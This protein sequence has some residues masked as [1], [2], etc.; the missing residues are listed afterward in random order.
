MWIQQIICGVIH[1]FVLLHQLKVTVGAMQDDVMSAP[2]KVVPLAFAVSD[3]L[4][5]F[6]WVYTFW[7]KPFL[8]QSL[9]EEI[10]TTQCVTE[11]RPWILKL[12]SVIFTSLPFG[13]FIFTYLHHGSSDAPVNSAIFIDY[14]NQTQSTQAFSYQNNSTGINEWE[15]YYK[16][17]TR[18][19]SIPCLF[20]Y[21]CVDTLVLILAISSYEITKIYAKTA[22]NIRE[23][24]KMRRGSADRAD[25]FQKYGLIAKKLKAY[26]GSLNDFGSGF[27]FA[28]FCMIVP[29]LSFRPLET[30][31]L[32]DFPYTF[33]YNWT[34]T[35]I[36]I[37]ILGCC[38][39]ATRQS[40]LFKETVQESAYELNYV[41]EVET[42]STLKYVKYAVSQC[43]VKGGRFFKFSYGLL[44]NIVCGVIHT[45]VLFHQLERTVG[46]MQD[47]VMSAPLKVVPL[48]FTVSDAL[49]VFV[50][51]YTFWRKPLLLQSL[52]VEISTTQCL[53][54]MRPWVLK[55][56]SL[57]FASLPFAS[58]TFTYLHH[59]SPDALNSVIIN[60]AIFSDYFNQTQSTQAFSY[61]SNSTGNISAWEIY[62]KMASRITG[63][64]GIPGLFIFQC[65]ETLVLILAISSYEITKSY[66]KSAA[67]IREEV[68]SRRGLDRADLFQK[69]GLIAK[70][71]KAYFGGLNDFGSGFYFAWFC[72]I[73]PWLSFRPLETLRHDAFPY[74]FMFNWTFILIYIIILGC[75]AEARRQCELL[76]EFTQESAYELN[77][78]AGEE[79]WTTLKYV[80]YAVSQC[81]VK[82]GRFFQ[83]SYG[84]LGN[85]I[86][87][88][89]A[90]SLLFIQFHSVDK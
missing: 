12:K 33:A 19:T 84:F 8:L 63:V 20:I 59:G 43:G 23:E 53:T 7:R 71:L 27:Y 10:S 39:E 48:A 6:F 26:F 79:I 17:A 47:D 35:L 73:V 40:E 11:M 81:G 14:Y 9:I 90:Y 16:L 55:L 25:L 34:F 38:A 74:T 28:W 83:F 41:A 44:G 58:F 85:T 18:I 36:Y 77:S 46:A 65:V 60:S 87:L 82:G 49:Y 1:T 57:I 4:Y 76:N 52:I 66:A 68:E 50:W 89:I 75:C 29:W 24:V 61:Q 5:V 3:S 80:K 13:C 78:V 22:A 70:K 45:F 51:V 15:T 56:K 67:N 30:L 72:M 32:D 21:Q 42:L 88:I 37:I 86:G 64:G 62:Y 54:E 69:Y 31:R 2:L